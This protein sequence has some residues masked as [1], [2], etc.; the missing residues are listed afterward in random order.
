[1]KKRITI[2]AANIMDNLLQLNANESINGLKPGERILVDSD[3]FSFVYL[4]EDHED[5]TYIVLTEQIWSFLKSALEQK[6]PVWLTFKDEKLELTNFL[7]DLKYVLS[8]IKDNSN[9]GDEMLVKVDK[10]FKS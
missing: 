10:I 8:N 2:L 7:E 4:M 5:Y 3:Q 9:Y 1:V 6:L